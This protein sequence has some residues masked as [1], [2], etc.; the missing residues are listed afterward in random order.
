MPTSA[1]LR[2]GNSTYGEMKHILHGTG[3]I[4]AATGCAF[5]RLL[6]IAGT[7]LSASR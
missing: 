3:E 7:S 6:N 2:D 4:S 5:Q 1:G